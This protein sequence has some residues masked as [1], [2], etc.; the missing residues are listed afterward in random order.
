M[1]E[2]VVYNK[3]IYILMY[4]CSEMF[5]KGEKLGS[6]MLAPISSIYLITTA[7]NIIYRYVVYFYATDGID[8]DDVFFQRNEQPLVK[9]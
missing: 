1:K 4:K 6:W 9:F 8:I 5:T 7:T 3:V 2:K